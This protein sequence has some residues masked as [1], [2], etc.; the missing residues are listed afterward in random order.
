MSRALAALIFNLFEEIPL[1]TFKSV[2]KFLVFHSTA[3]KNCYLKKEKLFYS[4]SVERVR[5]QLL[6]GKKKICIE[7]FNRT[8]TQNGIEFNF[9]FPK[10]RVFSFCE[11][12]LLLLTVL[13]SCLIHELN[14]TAERYK[15]NINFTSLQFP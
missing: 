7:T 14:C 11:N 3:K 13:S 4:P 5:K 8:R 6:N 10:R 9:P 12:R 1:S 15:I 2:L